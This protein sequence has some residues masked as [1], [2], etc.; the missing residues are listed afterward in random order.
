[1][2]ACSNMMCVC[3]CVYVLCYN[4]VCACSY[5]CVCVCIMCMCVYFFQ[6][7][8]ERV[9]VDG[10]G[11]TKDDIII[12]EVRPLLDSVTFQEV[13]LCMRVILASVKGYYY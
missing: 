4:Y 5:T 12:K 1:M 8:V 9:V 11:R 7:K 2:L 6:A 13:S 3:V 10:V